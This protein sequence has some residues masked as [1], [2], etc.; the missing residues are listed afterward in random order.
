MA[1]RMLPVRDCPKTPDSVSEMSEM[2]NADLVQ[3]ENR[4]PHRE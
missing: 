1:T 4:I 2:C 3:G